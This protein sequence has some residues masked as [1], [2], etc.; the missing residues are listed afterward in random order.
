MRQ[1]L[2]FAF[3]CISTVLVGQNTSLAGKI[4]DS[5]T[6]EEL[7]GANVTLYKNGVLT[8]GASTDFTGNYSMNL[9]PGTY[10]VEV[11]YIGYAPKRIVSVV[12]QAGRANKLD[13]QL[14]E[15]YIE[16][17]FSPAL[18]YFQVLDQPL[19][20]AEEEAMSREQLFNEAEC[21]R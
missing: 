1:I 13:V 6:G 8:T 5:E 3:V 16:W 21:N 2:I 14:G 18:S 12:V 4:Q 11:S 15:G 7:I 9:D 10:D 19:D 17:V 20:I